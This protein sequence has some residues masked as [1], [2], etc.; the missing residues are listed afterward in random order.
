MR[1]AA[2]VLSAVSLQAANHYVRAG[3]SGTGSGTDWTNACTA[4]SGSCSDA[5]LVR[6]DTYY[7][8]DGSYS[9]T[10]FNHADSGTLIITIKKAIVADHGTSTGWLDTYGDGAATFDN[11]LDF[12]SN[13]WTLDGVTGGGPSSWKTGFGFVI[14]T[15]GAHTTCISDGGG[16]SGYH[17]LIFRHIECIGD[18][19]GAISANNYC[20]FFGPG[21]GPV[22]VEYMYCHDIA[23]VM[24]FTRTHALTV[25]Y[26]YFD[27]I[28]PDPAAHTEAIYGA[29]NE[30]SPTTLQI[31]TDYVVRYNV[32]ANIG[33]PSDPGGVTGVLVCQCD[34]YEV[35]GNVIINGGGGQGGVT[36][37]NEMHNAKIYNNTFIGV[38]KGINFTIG[39]VDGDNIVAYNN[40]FY[41]TPATFGDPNTG[42][43]VTHNYSWC[44]LNS[45]TECTAEAND[46]NG[47]TSDPFVAYASDNFTL[48]TG[49]TAGTTL[50]SPYNTDP[51]GNTRGADGTWDRGAYEFGATEGGGSTPTA[52][53][54]GKA[55]LG[56]KASLH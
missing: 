51:L 13:Y 12:N 26:S 30:N 45:G 48:S 28:V 46:Q 18:A 8:A 42:G 19:G 14:D 49:T 16:S 41:D 1:I 17:D 27:T 21:T 39:A 7:V 23:G 4:F 11:N 9:Q 55:S 31:V 38:N 10:T 54:S 37:W 6:G 33:P 56:G 32:W 20:T 15:T 25:Q 2:L 53:I 40:L 5:N 34:R 47:G 43:T 24:L 29:A 50:G 35:Y 3:A 22:L 52:V 44:G 36:T